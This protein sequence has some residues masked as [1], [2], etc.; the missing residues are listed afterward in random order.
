M[1]KPRSR[2]SSAMV[3]AVL[4]IAF[5]LVGTAVAANDGALYPKLTKSKVKKIAKKQANKQLKANVNN[6]HVNLADQAT[7]AETADS[8]SSPNVVP[9][10]FF[11]DVN[12]SATILTVPGAEFQAA[13]N[14]D[15]TLN[16][17]GTRVRSTADNGIVKVAGIDE[18]QTAYLNQDDD[19]D[20]GDQVPLLRSNA[21]MANREVS[22]TVVFAG[23]GGTPSVTVTFGSEE[24]NTGSNDCQIWGTAQTP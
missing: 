4:A 24:S 2:P 10:T 19:F 3:V 7:N 20:Q 14:P 13:C 22:A 8:L 11:G 12:Q 16:F 9:F 23:Q 6:S 5:G 17:T 21:A 15:G 18:A 1:N